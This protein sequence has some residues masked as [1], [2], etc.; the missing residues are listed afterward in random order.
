[1][2]GDKA[3][4]RAMMCDAAKLRSKSGSSSL[5]LTLQ[6]WPVWQKARS[7]SVFAALP[8]EPDVLDPWPSDKRIALP[9]VHGEE[10]DFHW[11]AGRA[12]LVP[13]R[14]GI[15]EPS[16]D[17]PPAGCGF[18]LILVPGIAFDRCGGRLG[19][20][21]GYYDRFLARA[22][23]FVAGVCFDEQLIGKVPL[24]AHDVRMDA[25]VTPSEIFPA[26]PKSRE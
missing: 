9:R 19:R 12:G 11:T 18:D 21:R 5:V 14:F 17:S 8:G 22:S 6:T 24:E 4:L 13:G 1:M 3:A 2:S 16:A 15:L 10:L 25:I 20:G 26:E 23:G 7:V